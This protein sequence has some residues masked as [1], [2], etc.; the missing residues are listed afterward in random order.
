[1]TFANEI[2]A[3]GLTSG[4]NKTAYLGEVEVLSKWFKKNN[5]D[6]N[7]SKT[8]EVVGDFRESKE[9]PKLDPSR[10][11]D[12]SYLGVHSFLGILIGYTYL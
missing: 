10:E 5:L 2:I 9:L 4:Y 6:P 1:M 7:V 11:S 3:V 8:K 12:N